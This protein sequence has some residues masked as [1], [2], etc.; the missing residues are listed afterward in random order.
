MLG[1]SAPSGMIDLAHGVEPPAKRAGRGHN[2][3]PTPRGAFPGPC[4]GPWRRSR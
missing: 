1:A 4:R 3:V 2:D